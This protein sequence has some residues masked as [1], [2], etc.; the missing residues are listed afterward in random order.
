[1]T[2]NSKFI[3][4][5]NYYDPSLINT[6]EKSKLNLEDCEDLEDMSEYLYKTELLQIFGCKEYD[7]SVIDGIISDL[8]MK[9]S[10]PVEFTECMRIAASKFLSEDLEIGFT[11]LFSY[12]YMFL[13]HRCICDFLET[14]NMSDENVITLKNAVTK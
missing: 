13:T 7:S 12:N 3:C 14:V 1:M 4:T 9:L 6:I 5:Y 8:F 10:L 11:T 2:Y